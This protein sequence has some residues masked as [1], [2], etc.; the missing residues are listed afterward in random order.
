MLYEANNQQP[1]TANVPSVLR[2]PTTGSADMQQS[3]LPMTN[4]FSDQ[5]LGFH[6]LPDIN[7]QSTSEQSIKSRSKQAVTHST[8]R[9]SQQEPITPSLFQPAPASNQS[10]VDYPLETSSIIN[11]TT[12][13]TQMSHEQKM[14]L[15]RYGQI[16]KLQKKK[17]HGYVY[18]VSPQP[19][20]ADKT[21]S[22]A[23]LTP[24]VLFTTTRQQEVPRTSDTG[25]TPRLP[26][27]PPF[28]F[29]I[30][31]SQVRST[32]SSIISDTQS[33]PK[34]Q[35]LKINYPPQPAPIP[36]P[37]MDRLDEDPQ[38]TSNAS[39]SSKVTSALIHR[40]DSQSST[41]DITEV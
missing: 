7:V 8:P 31:S 29:P 30:P 9:V 3:R 21:S 20:S 38:E 4:T 10:T 28:E 32:P 18:G 23:I 24:K 34:N 1:N 25:R 13:C 17:R 36:P 33:K 22:D 5:S 26:T 12:Y 40:K 6:V 11:S 35:K 2:T 39:K 37:R 41:T 16:E 27:R 14:Q 15:W 19:T